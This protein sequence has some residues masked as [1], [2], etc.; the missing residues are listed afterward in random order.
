MK[1]AEGAYVF[2]NKMVQNVVRGYAS[3]SDYAGK[4]D[5]DLWPA[6]TAAQY[7]ANDLKVIERRAAVQEVETLVIH[8]RPRS[9]LSSKFPIFDRE[10]TRRVCGRNRHRC[11]GPDAG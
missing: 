5:A 7:R 9:L 2:V 8:E 4:T 1:T 11:Y 3:Y 10:G 6:E